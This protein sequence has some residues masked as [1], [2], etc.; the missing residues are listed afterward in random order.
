MQERLPAI[1]SLPN[2]KG[3]NRLLLHFG[4]LPFQHGSDETAGRVSLLF[5]VIELGFE[6]EGQLNHNSDE[7]WHTLAPLKMD[8][9]AKPARVNA[10]AMPC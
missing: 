9:Y 8:T 2:W 10:L 6:I 1:H 5:Q 4:K 7:F 3:R